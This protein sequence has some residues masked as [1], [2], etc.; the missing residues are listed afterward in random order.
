MAGTAV[1]D[2]LGTVQTQEGGGIQW[3]EELLAGLT[4]HGGVDGREDDVSDG[5]LPLA[6]EV[7][8]DGFEVVVLALPAFDPGGEVAHLAVETVVGQAHLGADEVDVL[9]GAQDPAVV[10]HV[11]VTDTQ[12]EVDEH[13]F[14]DG[15]GNDVGEDLP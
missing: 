12:A 4:G 1:E 8:G 9:V 2:N 14:A 5:D 6:G 13:V 10:A 7:G 15:V 3:G 11:A